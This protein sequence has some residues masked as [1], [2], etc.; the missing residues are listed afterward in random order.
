MGIHLDNFYLFFLTSAYL[1]IL[2]LSISS[3]ASS[4]FE[5]T[6]LMSSCSLSF[7]G[8]LTLTFYEI[9]GGAVGYIFVLFKAPFD[10]LKKLPLGPYLN[11][12]D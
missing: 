2:I 7:S 3:S 6:S 10:P 8:N 9:M 12:K 11:I 1:L 5:S 4:A